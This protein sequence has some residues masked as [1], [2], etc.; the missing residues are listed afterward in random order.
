MFGKGESKLT[1]VEKNQMLAKWANKILEAT[2]VDDDEAQLSML[3]GTAQEMG[4]VVGECNMNVASPQKQQ[5]EYEFEASDL[6]DPLD[7]LDS[8][9]FYDLHHW[10]VHLHLHHLPSGHNPYCRTTVTVH[11]QI[12]VVQWP[13]KLLRLFGR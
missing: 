4:Q 3:R 7:A 10:S 11:A 6:V 12:P 2:T 1:K 5:A 8:E 9:E 13:V